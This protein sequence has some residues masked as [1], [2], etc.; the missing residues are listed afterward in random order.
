MIRSLAAVLFAGLLAAA[1]AGAQTGQSVD[2]A[3]VIAAHERVCN[4]LDN[5]SR[6]GSAIVAPD[7]PH[8]IDPLVAACAIVEI[9]GWLEGDLYAGS[10][11]EQAA[12]RF[13]L[14]GNRAM[15]GLFAMTRL[16]DRGRHALASIGFTD[17]TL[18]LVLQHEQMFEIADHI[19]RLNRN[20]VLARIE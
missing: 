5:R 12:A 11:R 10:M 13:A 9:N 7:G 6:A 1:P 2:R 18:L 8:F 4:Y 20:P 19:S 3:D 15:D 14:H 17:T 16:P